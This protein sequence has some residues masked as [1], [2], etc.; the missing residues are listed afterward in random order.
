MDF[1]DLD[2]VLHNESLSETQNTHT[3]LGKKTTHFSAKNKNRIFGAR[4]IQV[5]KTK[6]IL[7]SEVGPP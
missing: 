2:V 5:R 3:L 6:H 4:R 1:H 7:F